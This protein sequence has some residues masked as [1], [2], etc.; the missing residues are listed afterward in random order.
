MVCLEEANQIAIVSNGLSLYELLEARGW[1]LLPALVGSK[2]VVWN[3]FL[4][5]WKHNSVCEIQVV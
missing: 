1:D 3:G 5:V 2:Q 4:V